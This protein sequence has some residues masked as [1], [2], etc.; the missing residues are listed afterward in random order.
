M[1]VEPLLQHANTKPYQ[2][3]STLSAYSDTTAYSSNY[4]A[5]P[6]VTKEL[7]AQQK[8]QQEIEYIKSITRQFRPMSPTSD[9]ATVRSE[10]PYEPQLTYN[11]PYELPANQNKRQALSSA[12]YIGKDLKM[13]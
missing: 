12:K 4:K 10:N 1:E 13:R 2:K 3:Q 6:Q 8:V 11:K 5:T 9:R 7:T